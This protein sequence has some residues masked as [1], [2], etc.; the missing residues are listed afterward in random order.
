MTPGNPH[1]MT[2]LDQ[3]ERCFEQSGSLD[4]LI[5]LNRLPKVDDEALNWRKV[6]FRLETSN[7][8]LEQVDQILRAKQWGQSE[9]RAKQL[10][11]RKVWLSWYETS[12]LSKTTKDLIVH[13]AFDDKP[14]M[15]LDFAH[16]SFEELQKALKSCRKTHP[17]IYE[18]IHSRLK[19][20]MPQ[21]LTQKNRPSKRLST[22]AQVGIA[23]LLLHLFRLLAQFIGF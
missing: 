9:L 8:R 15:L 7:Q 3:L 23:L 10:M 13:L 11:H 4:P 2:Y 6:F 5:R 18:T 20:A 17:P 14:G 21:L 22:L 16:P 1:L 19:E 12:S